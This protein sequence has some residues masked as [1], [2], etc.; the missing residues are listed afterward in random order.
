MAS[1]KLSPL[2]T[3]SNGYWELFRRLQGVLFHVWVG[4]GR[5][6]GVTWEDLSMEKFIM[7]EENFHEGGAGSSSII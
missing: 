5:G 6:E 1:Y 3:Y 2:F 4:V 7:R